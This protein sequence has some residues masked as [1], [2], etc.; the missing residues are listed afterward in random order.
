[1]SDILGVAYL[2]AGGFVAGRVFA[3]MLP[4]TGGEGLPALFVV[5]LL[6]WVGW[7]LSWGIMKALDKED[8][9]RGYR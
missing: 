1:M 9:E 8:D 7:P 3:R 2:I 6:A 5:T 4:H